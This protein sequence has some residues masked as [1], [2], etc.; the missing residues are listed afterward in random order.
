MFENSL[1]V[2]VVENNQAVGSE[3]FEVLKQNLA[4]FVNY[5]PIGQKTQVIE[6]DIYTKVSLFKC[7]QCNINVNFCLVLNPFDFISS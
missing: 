1:I 3:N 5:I 7:A 4:R 6:I 2:F